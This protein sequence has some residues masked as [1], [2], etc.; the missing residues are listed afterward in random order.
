LAN[1]AATYPTQAVTPRSLRQQRLAWGVLLAAFAL[2]GVLCIGTGLGLR[3]FLL[4]STVS[5]QGMLTVGRGTVGLTSTDLIEQ[6]VRGSREIANSSVIS[7][8]RQ[9]QAMLSFYDPHNPG[10][11]VATVTVRTDTA[12][13]LAA[14]SRPRFELSG[15]GYEITLNDLAG[16]LK[17]IIPDDL[18]RDV[19]VTIESQAG[20]WMTLTGGG[21]YFVEVSPNLETLTN[22][23]G[24]A[25]MISADGALSQLV[26]DTQRA[27][28]SPEAAEVYVVPAPVSLIQQPQFTQSTVIES[29]GTP[30]QLLQPAWRCYSVANGEPTGD[31]SIVRENGRTAL[32]MLRGGGARTHGETLCSRALNAGQGVDV[33]GFD[34]L[35]LDVLFKINS[36]SLSA[37]GVEGSECPV[38]VRVDYVPV[39]GGS[40]TSWFHGFF[41]TFDPNI[42]NPLVCASCTQEHEVVNA[43]AWYSYQSDNLFSLLPANARPEAIVNVVVYASGHEYDS[44]VA[45]AELFGGVRDPLPVSPD[46]AA[47]IAANAP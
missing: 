37:C 23:G 41:V 44:F 1:P 33:T 31:F 2:F 27:L 5:L 21:E 10:T 8:D 16:R 45:S 46:E 13:D 25:A 17:V 26:A 34:T 3:Y 30:A 24:S 22:Y 35:S 38:M 19:R 15:L 29:D 20:N 9:S 42:T 36:H 18:T 14:M 28:W 43:G 7:T 11:L 40:A 32:Q 4:D 12:L 47:E 39:G 6:V